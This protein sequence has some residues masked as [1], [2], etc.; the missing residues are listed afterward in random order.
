MKELMDFCTERKAGPIGNESSQ[1][2]FLLFGFES[3]IK[4]LYGKM[5]FFGALG[6]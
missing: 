1:S 6:N 5:L 4:F 3:W 2:A